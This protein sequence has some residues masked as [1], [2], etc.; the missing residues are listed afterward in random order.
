[1]AKALYC[2]NTIALQDQ[3]EKLLIKVK[4]VVR[5]SQRRLA[6]QDLPAE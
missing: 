6:G 1:M 2:I 4:I 5:G 3:F